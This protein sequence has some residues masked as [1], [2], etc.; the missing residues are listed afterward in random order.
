MIEKRLFIVSNRLPV[1]V[2]HAEEGIIISRS[3][4]PIAD[5]ISNFI[6]RSGRLEHKTFSEIYWAGISEC[7][8]N[9]WNDAVSKMPEKEF[10]FLPVFINKRVYD[11]YYNVFANSVL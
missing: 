9:E 5:S 11:P 7:T 6:K 3:Q 10:H 1:Q 8:T 4:G 2:K